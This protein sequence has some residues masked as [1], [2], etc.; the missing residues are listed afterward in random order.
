MVQ[1]D[2]SQISTRFAKLTMVLENAAGI[3]SEGQQNGLEHELFKELIEGLD[4]ALTQA[5]AHLEWLRGH[6]S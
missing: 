3:A 6:L 5:K 2:N 4:D 1:N